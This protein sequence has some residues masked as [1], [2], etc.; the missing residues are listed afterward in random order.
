MNPV[1]PAETED[2]HEGQWIVWDL[3]TEQFVAAGDELEQ[4]RGEVERVQIAG[5]EVYLHYVLPRG[6]LLVGGL[7]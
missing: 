4:L 1:I 2:Q 7:L 3:D 6:T 5:H